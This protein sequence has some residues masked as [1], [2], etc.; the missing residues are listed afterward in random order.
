MAAYIP[1]VVDT[2]N[3]LDNGN[4][5]QMWQPGRT[6]VLGANTPWHAAL[7]HPGAFQM[8]HIRRLFESRPFTK[9]VPA[10]E[11]IADGPTHG[12]AKIRAARA[13]DGSFAFVYSPRGEAFSVEMSITA[14]S[15]VQA[16][17]YDPRY[18]T[19]FALHT[20]DNAAIQ[21]FVPPSL[22]RGQDW[23]LV[24]DHADAGFPAPGATPLTGA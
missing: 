18:G 19:A 22:G 7:D 4:I 13:S 16:S 17:W 14:P 2:V 11:F 12:G 10:T 1:R 15:Q 9:L 24:L 21:T 6:P 23:V 3:D 20:G 5:W 8:G